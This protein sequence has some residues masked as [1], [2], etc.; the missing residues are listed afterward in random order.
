MRR[1][2]KG[3][4]SMAVMWHSSMTVETVVHLLKTGKIRG[5]PS[6]EDRKVHLG[7]VEALS[8]LFFQFRVFFCCSEVV[9]VLTML[10]F[11]LGIGC[12]SLFSGLPL[13]VG[14]SNSRMLETFMSLL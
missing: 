8:G 4:P 14:R 11:W 3:I 9:P 1:P 13:R 7:T 5:L 10:R 12:W 2:E 6:K